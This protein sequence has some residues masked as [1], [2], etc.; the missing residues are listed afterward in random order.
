MTG[1]QPVGDNSNQ[2]HENSGTLRGRLLYP[3]PWQIVGRVTEEYVVPHREPRWHEK[4]W[5]IIVGFWTSP[6]GEE[7]ICKAI[8]KVRPHDG[9]LWGSLLAAFAGLGAEGRPA[10]NKSSH[11]A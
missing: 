1:F 7:L 3:F 10:R 6:T 9:W 4:A 5:G 2:S 8:H 11:C